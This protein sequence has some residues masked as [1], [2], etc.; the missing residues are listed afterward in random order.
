MTAKTLTQALVQLQFIDDT[1]Y[2]NYD[3]A[4]SQSNGGLAVFAAD[5]QHLLNL[6]ARDY[7]LDASFH[8]STRSTVEAMQQDLESATKDR[9]HLPGAIPAPASFV[10]RYSVDVHTEVEFRILEPIRKWVTE[11]VVATR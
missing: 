6:V 1:N 5:V 7:T 2:V 9:T 8:Q 4:N 11:L 10:A 3:A